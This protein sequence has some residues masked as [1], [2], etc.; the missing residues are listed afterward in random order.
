MVTRARI[1]EILYNTLRREEMTRVCSYIAGLV[2]LF[3]STLAYAEEVPCPPRGV[4]VLVPL[5]RAAGH[6]RTTRRAV[7][8]TRR[9]RKGHPLLREAVQA[10]AHGLLLR[11]TVQ[12]PHR[13]AGP[14][15]GTE[16]GEG[17]H[18]AQ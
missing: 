12:E 17:P 6:G 3:A 7:L 9:V 2:V 13:P 11:A 4:D 1:F 18:A 5:V 15:S 16:A 8:P 10:A 14:G